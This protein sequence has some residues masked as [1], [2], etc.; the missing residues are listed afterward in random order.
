MS[1]TDSACHSAEIIHGLV[2]PLFMRLNYSQMIL[3]S[4]GFICLHI[5]SLER[6]G[7]RPAACCGVWGEAEQRGLR[8]SG[9]EL[10]DLHWVWNQNNREDDSGGWRLGCPGW[11]NAGTIVQDMKPCLLARGWGILDPPDPEGLNSSHHSCSHVHREESRDGLGWDTVRANPPALTPL[12]NLSSLG[13]SS[14]GTTTLLVPLQPSDPQWGGPELPVWIQ[15]AERREP[16][17]WRG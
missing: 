9:D 4:T 11:V 12:E 1:G 15:V 7:E 10:L 16:C 17:A 6:T 2:Q 5:C 13:P 8:G 14:G 3:I